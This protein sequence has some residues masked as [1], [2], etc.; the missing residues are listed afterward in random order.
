MKDYIVWNLE[1]EHGD[2]GLGSSARKPPLSPLGKSLISKT[3]SKS[4]QIHANEVY[5][6]AGGHIGLAKARLD[7]IHSMGSLE[8][9][10]TRRDQ[11]PVNIVTMFDF[12]L[13]RI[14]NQPTS[15]CDIA[16][17]SIAAAS[18]NIKG[19][20]I[21]EL[22]EILKIFGAAETRSGEDILEATRGFLLGTT[23]DDPQRIAV[24]HHSF[25]FYIAERYH[26]GIHRASLQIN[27]PRARFEPQNVSE[28][29]AKVT[30]HK[31]ARSNTM[32]MIK[33]EPRQPFML[34]K[35]TR[36]WK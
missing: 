21:P 25:F 23:R 17:K 9:I 2:L 22:R 28:S 4:I 7:L 30:P 34:R 6:S 18:I 16:L 35:G 31:M 8:G 36:A 13:K 26:R 29:P 11:L 14:E 3:A 19:V 5:D 20:E 24:Y 27:P 10:E 15:Q 33:E 1:R 12:G 32:Q